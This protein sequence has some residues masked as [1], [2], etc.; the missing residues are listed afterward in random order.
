MP[1]I[2]KL[3]LTRTV[4]FT[5]YVEAANPEQAQEAIQDAISQLEDC[6]PDADMTEYFN[7][8]ETDWDTAP[9]EETI[10]TG[11]PEEKLLKI[12]KEN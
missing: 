1:E 10:V 4:K 6:D 5:A 8:V 7:W 3:D 9:G 2:Y 12:I 11:I